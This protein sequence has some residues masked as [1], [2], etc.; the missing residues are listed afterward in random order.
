MEKAS[1]ISCATELNA[2]WLV[3]GAGGTNAKQKT[4]KVTIL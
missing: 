4:I 1:L 2:K 3:E